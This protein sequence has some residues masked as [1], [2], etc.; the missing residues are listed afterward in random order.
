MKTKSQ[1]L[2]A[3]L[4]FVI[5]CE[6]EN[7]SS[8]GIRYPLDY[9]NF[10]KYV[11]KQHISDIIPA[12]G[13]ITDTVII[14][15]IHVG[16]YENIQPATAPGAI[17]VTHYLSDSSRGF[18]D[19]Y[20]HTNKG[21]FCDH[22]GSTRGL[23][24]MFLFPYRY[25][26]YMKM[27]IFTGIFKSTHEYNFDEKTLIYPLEIGTRW[28][29]NASGEVIKE[30]IAQENINING[31]SADAFKIEYTYKADSEASTIE[32][33]SK[34][35]ML[36]RERIIPNIEIKDPY[37]SIGPYMANY[38]ETWELIEYDLVVK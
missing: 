18:I 17:I 24:T 9:G 4:F 7:N 13:N 35:G 11:R 28:E 21:L 30:V 37:Q 19:F 2:L 5:A 36:K 1:I 32:Y 33:V 6:T 16:V 22:S 20:S 8:N 23:N 38:R 10:W 26:T 14:D 3:M 15:T 29:T 31:I 25:E 27:D 34:I 12:Y